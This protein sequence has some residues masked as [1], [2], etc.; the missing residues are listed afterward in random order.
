MKCLTYCWKL[1]VQYILQNVKYAVWISFW[2]DSQVRS[3]EGRADS[4]AD[5]LPRRHLGGGAAIL[6]P[7]VVTS[8]DALH[9]FC[10]EG[11]PLRIGDRSQSM[12]V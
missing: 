3:L 1:D 10:D 2:D 8:A 5:T 9:L 12:T 6:Q 7:N 4:A 11:H